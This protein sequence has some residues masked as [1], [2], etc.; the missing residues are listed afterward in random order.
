MRDFVEVPI[1][2]PDQ[3]AL[4]ASANL[5]VGFA[6]GSSF[7]DVRLGFGIMDCSMHRDDV[8]GSVELAVTAA[9]ESV[10]HGVT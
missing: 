4:Q 1:D 9:V 6:L 7:F 2:S 8:E 3:I 10:P 5:P